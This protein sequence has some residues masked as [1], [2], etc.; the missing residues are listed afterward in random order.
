MCSVTEEG[1]LPVALVLGARAAGRPLP[2]LPVASL[3]WNSL[4]HSLV[5]GL[6][7]PFPKPQSVCLLQ[8][9]KGGHTLR[10]LMSHYLEIGSSLS[11]M[12]TSRG[13][14]TVPSS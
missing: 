2:H 6:S 8:P 13:L 11:S 3:I 4:F 5:L 14:W 10:L 12:L 1:L 9:L 7:Q